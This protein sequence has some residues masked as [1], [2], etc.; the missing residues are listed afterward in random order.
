[1]Q[2]LVQNIMAKAGISEQQAMVAINTT[3]DYIKSKVPPP[4][5]GMVDNFF[6]GNFDPMAGMK[7]AAGAQSDFMS[8]AKETF[9]DAGEKI[10][11]F[12]EDAI[13]K[14]AEFARQATQ[15][16]HEWAKQAGGWSEEA[17]NKIKDMFGSSEKAGT[18][19]NAGTAGNRQ[20]DQSGSGQK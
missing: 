7:A 1:M 2:E 3:K 9:Q 10:S 20:A 12:T 6:S 17:M 16:M 5:A 15:H 4:A 19:P 14:G 18:G 13:D 8:K 11:D